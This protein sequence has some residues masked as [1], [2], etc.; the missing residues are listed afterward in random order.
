MLVEVLQEYIHEV[1]RSG[2]H[3][4]SA[5]ESLKCYRSGLIGTVP[6]FAEEVDPHGFPGLK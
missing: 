5:D 4:R 2:I 6:L 1:R 3:L